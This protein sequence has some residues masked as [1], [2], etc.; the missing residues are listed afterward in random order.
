M[1]Y[2]RSVYFDD[3]FIFSLIIKQVADL[4]Y[5]GIIVWLRANILV[6]YLSFLC[7]LSCSGQNQ[8]PV[9]HNYYP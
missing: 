5:V 6:K 7:G 8:R 3:V 9:V 2:D 4:S 1:N